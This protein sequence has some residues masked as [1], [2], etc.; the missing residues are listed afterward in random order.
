M[1]DLSVA[2]H[3]LLRSLVSIKMRGWVLHWNAAGQNSY[4]DHLLYERIYTKVDKSIDALGER[5][6]AYTGAVDPQ[7]MSA[8]MTTSVSLHKLIKQAQQ[9]S[10]NCVSLLPTANTESTTGLEN[11]LNDLN[12]RLD[13]FAYLLKQRGV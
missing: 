3:K 5:I 4:G 12:D 6:V 10:D 1:S 7:A 9:L 11:Y 8:D 13:T 2:L